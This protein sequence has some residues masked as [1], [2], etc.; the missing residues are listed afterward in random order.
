M[1]IHIF[2]AVGAFGTLGCVMR[3]SIH[4]L[5]VAIFS[6]GCRTDHMYLASET[7]KAVS[8]RRRRTG[9]WAPFGG[10]RRWNRGL[11][12]PGRREF[13]TLILLFFLFDQADSGDVRVDC[14][15]VKTRKPFARSFSFFFAHAERLT[16]LL[17][18]GSDRSSFGRL[19][20]APALHK[21]ITISTTK[22]H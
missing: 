5:P 19:S 2:L 17:L 11:G 15:S 21:N 16:Q 9:A 14:F 4:K 1:I 8:Y 22:D 10:R 18:A 12:H 20:G 13:V 7:L 3:L 6:L